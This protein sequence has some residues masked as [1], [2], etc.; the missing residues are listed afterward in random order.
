MIEIRIDDADVTSVLARLA[1]HL[2]DMTPAMQE[3][4]EMLVAS[5]QDRIARGETPEGSPFAPRS[6]VTLARYAAEGT[7]FGNP[8]NVT[9]TL[10]GGI[11]HDAGPDQVRVGAPAIQSAVMQF[12]AGQGAFGRSKRGGPIPWGNIPPRPFLGLSDDDRAGIIEIVAEWIERS[13]ETR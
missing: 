9:G 1:A 6:A 8:L 10:R 5:T 4:G 2:T 11:F 7:R 13:V 12:G 3:I